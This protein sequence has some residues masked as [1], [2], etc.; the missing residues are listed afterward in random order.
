[1]LVEVLTRMKDFELA[2]APK[3]L[4]SNFISGP[5]TMPVQVHARSA[6][7]V[8]DRRAL[9]VHH[10]S[11][12]PGLTRP[13]IS[14]TDVMRKGYVYMLASKPYGTLYIGVTN[15]LAE[16]VYA[17]RIGKA[18]RFTTKHKVTR[19][20]WWEEHDLVADAIRRETNLKR[21]KTG[22]EN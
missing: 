1:M 12:W 15:N 16:R 4:P 10:N 13:P 3:W 19:L 21:W 5:Q 17:H 22:L 20:V 14:R 7:G 18:S 8:S 11:S 9:S 2:G 6:N